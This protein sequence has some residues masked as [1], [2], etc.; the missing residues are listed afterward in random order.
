MV[1]P[2]PQ[3]PKSNHDNGDDLWRYVGLGLQLTVTIGLF[4]VLGWW[5]DRKF[6]YEPWG[7]TVL[8]LVGIA[9]GLYHFVKETTA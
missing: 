9:V 2:D 4:V 5:V 3:A 1:H 7:I 8:S 6:G